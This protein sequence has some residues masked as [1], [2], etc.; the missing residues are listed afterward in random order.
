MPSVL[1]SQTE[2]GR[3]GLVIDRILGQRQIV[4]R[5]MRDPLIQVAGVIGATELGDGRP[6]LILDPLALA[7][8]SG[9]RSAGQAVSAIGAAKE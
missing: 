9:Q 1:V 6:L 2:R 5:S 8:R 7:R 4:V 3:V